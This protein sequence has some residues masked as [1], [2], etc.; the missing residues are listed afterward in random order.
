MSPWLG[1]TGAPEALQH[2]DHADRE[3]EHGAGGEGESREKEE[4]AQG[5]IGKFPISTIEFQLVVK[6]DGCFPACPKPSSFFPFPSPKAQK[7]K[8]EGTPDSRGRKK[9]LKL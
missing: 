9:K 4:G 6:F 1:C 3:R 2:P 7:R 5:R 8:S